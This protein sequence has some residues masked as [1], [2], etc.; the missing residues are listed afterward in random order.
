[1]EMLT[2]T[3]GVVAMLTIGLTQLVK[4]FI[5]PR[6]KTL[7]P[8]FFGVVLS[9]AASDVSVSAALTGLVVGLSAA[10]LYD[11]KKLKG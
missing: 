1:M 9:M 6:Y 3:N 10:G 7:I 4:K 11:Q 8:V 2:I 5:S